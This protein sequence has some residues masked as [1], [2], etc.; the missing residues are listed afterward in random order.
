MRLSQSITSISKLKAVACIALAAIGVSSCRLEN[1]PA[2]ARVRLGT[3]RIAT[4][5]SVG[6]R[7]GFSLRGKVTRSDVSDTSVYT[8]AG[9]GA[10]KSFIS[11]KSATSPDTARVYYSLPVS[12]PIRLDT[13]IYSVLFAQAQ[14]R[15]AL[16]IKDKSDSLV[17]LFGTLLPAELDVLQAQINPQNLRVKSGDQ[18]LNS[19][20]TECG[21]EG[22]FDM[23]FFDGFGWLSLQPGKTA[24][25]A[26]GDRL[27]FLANVANTSLIKNT[28][29]CVEP[30]EFSYMII[31]Q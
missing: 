6:T 16:L 26:N 3:I 25:L 20:T 10:F 23:L 1:E 14:D 11:F 29:G 28:G 22:D 15:S 17:C 4:L 24:S 18:A 2:S 13:S 19:R 8:V 31:K 27:Y 9:V 5:A 12:A 30:G 7:A 21:R